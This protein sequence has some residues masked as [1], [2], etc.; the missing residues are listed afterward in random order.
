VEA[1]RVPRSG[2]R[3]NFFFL[4]RVRPQA[5]RVCR[6]SGTRAKNLFSFSSPRAA[7]RPA[8]DE[9]ASAYK[10]FFFLC[11]LEPLRAKNLFSS[12]RAMPMASANRLHVPVKWA[13]I[14]RGKR[15]LA[16]DGAR[17]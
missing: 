9:V 5:A 6:A 13:E 1:A 3:Q 11:A 8:C 10:S 2:Q 12:P 14:S 4:R 17:R 16:H 15:V 7:K